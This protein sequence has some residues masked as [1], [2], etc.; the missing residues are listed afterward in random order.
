MIGEESNRENGAYHPNATFFIPRSLSYCVPCVKCVPCS[1]FY[2]NT[3]V[4]AKYNFNYLITMNNLRFLFLVIGVTSSAVYAQNLVPN[5]DFEQRDADYCGI[6]LQDGLANSLADW[7][8]P[9]SGSPDV[10][11][12]DIEDSCWNFQPNSTYPG[13]IG[14]KGSQLPRSG[15]S[16]VGMN[17]YTIQGLNQRD[18]IQV[19]LTS[20]LVP[21][22]KYLVEF[23]LSLADNTE[24]A[25]NNMGFHL[26]T[27][28]VSTGSGVL[29]VTPDYFT[30]NVIGDAQGWVRVADT[31]TASDAYAY[32]TIGNFTDDNATYVIDNP[33]ALPE[34]GL[35]GAYY[36]IDDVRVERVF[37]DSTSSTNE[38]EAMNVNIYPNPTKDVLWIEFPDET[39]DYDVQLTDIHGKLVWYTETVQKV[40]R[41]EL[42][43][44]KSGLYFVSVKSE[45]GSYTERIVKQ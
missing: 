35:Y 41:I 21:T 26:S 12:T 20:P 23:Y 16:M 2:R 25:S 31:I 6:A 9:S 18:Y 38:L 27:S 15:S 17:T 1:K 22:G 40:Q 11:F 36:F 33:T 32:L 42:G 8:S 14:L 19:Q 37:D 45:Q 3:N 29:P 44:F 30:T 34:P 24:F 5:P 10:F 28:M 7:Y 39:A 4:Q 13:P 43:A